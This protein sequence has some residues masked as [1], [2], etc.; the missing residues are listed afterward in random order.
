MCDIITLYYFIIFIQS[1]HLNLKIL[2]QDLFG[3]DDIIAVMDFSLNITPDI[4]GSSVSNYKK[5]V[6]D[7]TAT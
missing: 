5:T 2:D 3:S 6:V 1:F 7:G 4:S